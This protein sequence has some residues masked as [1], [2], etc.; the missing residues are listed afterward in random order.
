MGGIPG[1]RGGNL[2]SK[3]VFTAVGNEGAVLSAKDGDLATIPSLEVFV[4]ELP[5][6]DTM[7]ESFLIVQGGP[8]TVDVLIGLMDKKSTT[9]YLCLLVMRII[10]LIKNSK[11]MAVNIPSPCLESCPTSPMARTSS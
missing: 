4:L 10:S 7:V 1:G 11:A 2:D 6:S 9:M 8:K 3:T 5:F